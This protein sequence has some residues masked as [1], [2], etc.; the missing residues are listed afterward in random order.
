MRTENDFIA[1]L[2]FEFFEHFWLKHCVATFLSE[3]LVHEF[4]RVPGMDS[5]KRQIPVRSE[6]KADA[7]ATIARWAR[8]RPSIHPFVA[9]PAI[10]RIS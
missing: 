1:G 4:A 5:K 3:L 10:S 8:F 7:A 9:Q 2:S 6:Q